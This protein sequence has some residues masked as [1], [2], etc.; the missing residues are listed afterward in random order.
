MRHE[1]TIGLDKTSRP[2]DRIRKIWPL[3]R[4]LIGAV[5]P[6]HL[7]SVL[8]TGPCEPIIRV[9][10]S[11]FTSLYFFCFY[12][13]VSRPRPTPAQLAAVPLTDFRHLVGTLALT[14]V[15]GEHS[16]VRLG[17]RRPHGAGWG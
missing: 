14:V 4:I 6:L 1:R 13:P 8:F 17:V 15:L 3:L 9:L 11:L 2:V 16:S 5:F 7:P 12:V 10:Q